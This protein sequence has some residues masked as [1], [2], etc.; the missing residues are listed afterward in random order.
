MQKDS[1]GNIL[2]VEDDDFISIAETVFLKSKGYGVITA[3][4]GDKALK[5]IRENDSIYLVLMDIE[6]GEGMSGVETARRILEIKE[7][8]VVFLTSYSNREIVEQ[9]NS[10]T[11]YGYVTK[12]V[13][14]YVL[15]STIEMALKL[16]NTN[17]EL[18]ESEEK[19]RNLTEVS[20]NAILIHQNNHFVY[21]NP[22]G[23][24]I[25]GYS[26]N[27]L[28]SMRY[29][30][31]VAPEFRDD[32]MDRAK[33][34]MDDDSYSSLYEIRIITRDG[35]EKWVSMRGRNINY[36]GNPAR[37]ITVMDNTEIKLSE[38]KL[39]KNHEIL[40]AALRRS[41]ELA[42][43]AESANMAKSRFL[44][45]MSHEI[46][47]PMNGVI[48]MLD[49]LVNTVLD[50]EQAKYIDIARKS[51]DYL[52][53]LINDI[54]DLEKIESD[55]FTLNEKIFNLEEVV[56]SVVLLLKPKAD[57][58]NIKLEY[59][60]EGDIPHVLKGDYERLRQVLINI[61]D[62]RYKIY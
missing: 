31:I 17:R 32:V 58:K 22:A 24:Y 5:I 51:G 44:A 33:M 60:M 42:C 39:K 29:W 48:G 26:V 7:I 35:R 19:F 12:N 1:S 52:L 9:V 2:L 59:I 28:C 43:R 16:F 40:E 55:K 38:I 45:N 41:E 50:E 53:K 62:K 46:R 37:M 47:T 23:E 10:V 36:R 8:P 6:L 49:I 27:E 13:G 56:Q 14:D 11:R 54:L 3:S 4:D 34:V 61:T 15:I 30:D 18:K 20:P 57:K 25:S 21:S